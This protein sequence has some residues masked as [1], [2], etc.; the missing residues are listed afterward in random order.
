MSAILVPW[1][2]LELQA[3]SKS[4]V[5]RHRRAPFFLNLPYTAIG[6]MG[7]TH[8]TIDGND[9]WPFEISLSKAPGSLN[10]WQKY[11]KPSAWEKW[12]YIILII[13]AKAYHMNKMC[14]MSHF[15]FHD[16]LFRLE[17][18]DCLKKEVIDLWQLPFNPPLTLCSHIYMAMSLSWN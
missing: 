17:F 4:V 14:K 8:M 10:M 13:N 7:G 9:D 5:W 3:E 12:F 15:H 11:G 16:M 2:Q 1:T 6:K 18:G